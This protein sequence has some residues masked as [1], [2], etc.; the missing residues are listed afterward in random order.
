MQP[1]VCPLRL[2][3][4]LAVPVGGGGRPASIT[5]HAAS[6]LMTGQTFCY[7]IICFKSDL[8]S[9]TGDQQGLRDVASQKLPRMQIYRQP[10][11]KKKKGLEGT[12]ELLQMIAAEEQLAGCWQ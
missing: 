11:K 3:S 5:G 4:A 2:E 12:K 7:F 6:A 1:R 9:R 10:L 8:G